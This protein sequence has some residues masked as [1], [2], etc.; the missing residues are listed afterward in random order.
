M[1]V[2]YSLDFPCAYGTPTYAG[3]FRTQPEDFQVDEVLG[4]EPQGEGEHVYLHIRK[5]GENTAWVAEQIARLAQVGINDVGYGGR[6]DRHAVTTQWFS[7]YLPKTEEPD[8]QGLNSDSVQ[9]LAQHRHSRKLRRGEHEENQF[10][11]RL[12]NIEQAAVSEVEQRLQTVATQ[13]VPNYFGE[14]RFGHQGNNLLMAEQ[15]FSGKAIRDKQKRGLVL[16]AARS[17]LFNQ[18]LAD[19]VRQHNWSMLLS[20]DP[21]N[22]PSGP[23]WGRGRLTSTLA[24]LAL[25]QET[26]KA[27]AEWCNA[28]EHVGLQQERRPLVLQPR[29]LTWAWESDAAT[30]H[31]VISFTLGSGE[32]ATAVLREL[33]RVQSAVARSE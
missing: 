3:D 20:G 12:R 31:L 23:L 9:L 30:R 32:F 6:K 22:V 10:V 15:L 13:G 5:R 18:L 29:G 19:R 1:S 11:I 7:I 4:F 28:L 17:Y 26:L 33:V 2:S 24:T 8:W 14:Q 27:W 16:S 21:E 25:E